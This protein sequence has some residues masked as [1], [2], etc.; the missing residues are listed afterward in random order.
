MSTR[1]SDLQ[2]LEG[3]FERLARE[4]GRTPTFVEVSDEFNRKYPN[5]P[6]DKAQPKSHN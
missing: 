3:I 4:L 5:T 1:K 6:I 2:L